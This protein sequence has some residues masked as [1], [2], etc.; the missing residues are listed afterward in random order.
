MGLRK[1]RGKEGR[2]HFLLLCGMASL[3]ERILSG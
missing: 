1:G 3:R 2:D